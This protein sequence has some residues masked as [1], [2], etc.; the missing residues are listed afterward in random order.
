M[1][2]CGPATTK[3]ERELHGQEKGREGGEPAAESREFTKRF[4]M[5]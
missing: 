2:K 5:L 4:Y 1:R 3:G